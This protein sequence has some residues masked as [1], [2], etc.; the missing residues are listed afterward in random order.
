MDDVRRLY[1]KHDH[2]IIIT[3]AHVDIN[4]NAK[5]KK[6]PKACYGILLNPVFTSITKSEHVQ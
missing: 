3:A 5:P 4:E 2:T 1:K 6:T